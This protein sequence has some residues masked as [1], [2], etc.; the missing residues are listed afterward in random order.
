MA[1]ESTE[2]SIGIRFSEQFYNL[3]KSVSTI[4]KAGCTIMFKGNVEKRIPGNHINIPAAAMFTHLAAAPD[5][6]DFDTKRINI[7]SL[8]EFVKYAELANFPKRGTA[9][10]TVDTSITGRKYE[11]IKFSGGGITCRTPTAD[12]SCFKETH[13]HIPY[14]RDND[15]MTKLGEMHFSEEMVNDFAKKLRAVPTC[16]FITMMID[17]GGIKLYI[18]GKM[19]QQIT[20][21]VPATCTRGLDRAM[22]KKVFRPGN[23]TVF[24]VQLFNYMKGIGGEYDIDITYASF[25]GVEQMSLKATSLV[26]GANP[27]KP[28]TLWMG[29]AE[30]SAGAHSQFDLVQ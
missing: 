12:P 28:M 24:P 4:T 2:Q 5:D 6:L 29:A 26:P 25:K 30:C 22:I 10:L 19:S 7:F 23:V 9:E 3:L 20:Y 11:Y 27:D 1:E 21:C 18:K 14:T 15:P 8:N 17:D 13:V 16:E